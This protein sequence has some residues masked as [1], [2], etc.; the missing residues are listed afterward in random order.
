MPA[1][2][3]TSPMGTVSRYQVDTAALI[4]TGRRLIRQRR[5]V[6][7]LANSARRS[8]YCFFGR[9]NHRYS[10]EYPSGKQK[11]RARAAAPQG[12]WR[13]TPTSGRAV[14]SSRGSPSSPSDSPWS[15]VFSFAQ[16]QVQEGCQSQ[17]DGIWPV[18]G[19]ALSGRRQWVSVCRRSSV[20][21]PLGL[22]VVFGMSRCAVRHRRTPRS[23]SAGLCRETALRKRSRAA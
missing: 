17:P 1:G 16:V 12:L 21:E 8:G 18:S 6:G 22:Q 23:G 9:W 3:G 5:R 20:L 15:L 7:E 13:W 19:K 14:R 10:L 2:A 4:R 11:S